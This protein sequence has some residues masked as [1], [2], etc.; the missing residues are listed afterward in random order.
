MGGNRLGGSI[1]FDPD[2]I[3]A[4]ETI[5]IEGVHH[6]DQ[7]GGTENIHS[8]DVESTSR[9]RETRQRV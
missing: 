3:S 8:T 2:F 1:T 4:V 5:S 6:C 9:E 7:A